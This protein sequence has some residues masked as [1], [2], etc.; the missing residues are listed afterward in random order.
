[1]ATWH[2]SPHFQDG[3]ESKS[4]AM[5]ATGLHSPGSVMSEAQATFQE[6]GPVALNVGKGDGRQS[7][8]QEFNPGKRK[9]LLTHSILTL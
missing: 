2:K 7:T 1:M 6:I 8:M 4:T 5:I 3:E 9:V